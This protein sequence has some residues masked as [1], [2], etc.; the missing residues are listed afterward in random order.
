MTVRFAMAPQDVLYLFTKKQN[1]RTI[2]E[3]FLSE[4]IA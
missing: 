4:K 1:K 2:A 3:N